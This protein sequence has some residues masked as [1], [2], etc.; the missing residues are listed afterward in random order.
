VSARLDKGVGGWS[1]AP[2]T[3]VVVPTYNEA[4]TIERLVRSVLDE[5]P[6]PRRVLVVDDASPDGTGQISAR[7][8]AEL[9]DV[10]VLHRL[11]KLGLGPAYVAG[12]RSALGGG[13]DLVVQMDA[14]LS[15]DPVELPR[16]LAAAGADGGQGGEAPGADLVIGSR[17][18]AGG[19]VTDWGAGRVAISRWGSR[20]ARTVLGLEIQD[21]TS[22]F[23]CWRRAALECL[24]L[25]SVRSQGYAFQVE[26]TY[27]A[28]LAGLRVVE[29]PITF[30][31]RR[32]GASKM[33]GS[34]V[35]EAAWRI[36]AMRLRSD[37]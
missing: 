6:P 2:Y 11:G 19:R 37:R 9:D 30:H 14:D 21:M 23:K 36:P 17:Y 7:L 28:R 13:A 33:T 24:D 35:A 10:E 26:M 25:G 27:R 4:E 12:F 32:I 5:L 34:I 16:L 22:G 29:V 3:W 20:Y 1:A 31:D 15:H 8:A 18:V